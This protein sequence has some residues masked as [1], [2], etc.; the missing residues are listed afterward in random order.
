MQPEITYITNNSTEQFA[1]PC[2]LKLYCHKKVEIGEKVV[3]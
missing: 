3:L 2:L 1:T